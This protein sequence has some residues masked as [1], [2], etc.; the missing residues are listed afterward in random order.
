MQFY[1]LFIANKM[2]HLSFKSG[3]ILRIA[4]NEMR[5]RLQLKKTKVDVNIT[6]QDVVAAIQ[7]E[8]HLLSGKSGCVI[9]V[10]K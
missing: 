1:S 7:D 8:M 10:M 2:E 9:Q 4:S 6:A 3:S 5:H